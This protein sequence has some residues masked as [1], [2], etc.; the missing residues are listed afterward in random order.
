MRITYDPAKRT[1]TIAARGLDFDDAAD[2]FAG[3]TFETEDARKDYGEQRIICFGYLRG[4][5]VVVVYTQRGEHR[6]V[7][8]MRRANERE[9]KRIASQIGL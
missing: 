7:F 3:V 5:L 9:K 2:V 4:R 8:S 6:H 1:R